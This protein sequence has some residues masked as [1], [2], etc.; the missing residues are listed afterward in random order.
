MNDGLLTDAYQKEALSF[1]YAQAIAAR[2][3]YSTSIPSPDRNGVDLQVQAG[4]R[5]RPALD[6]QL[7]STVSLTGTGDGLVR[8]PLNRRNYDLLRIHSQVPRLLAILDLPNDI[9]QWMTISAEKL[10]LRNRAY[11]LSLLGYPET[12]NQKSN[13]VKMP[14]ENLFNVNNLRRLMEQS[15][16]GEI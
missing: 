6:L 15:R 7:K 3:R 16:K 2:S 9:D 11:W 13:T 8:Y 5:L 1:I 12:K 10:V 14:E 4:G